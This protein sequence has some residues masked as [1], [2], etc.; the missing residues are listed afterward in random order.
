MKI[1]GFVIS[2][3]KKG[4]YFISQK[5]Y[6]EQIEEKLGFKPFP[7][8]LNIQIQEGNLEQIAK[9]PLEEI[10]TI[11]GK[12][13]FGDVKYIKASLNGEINGA[14]VFPVKTQHPQDI[15]EFIANVNLREHLT[16]EDGALVSLDIKVIQG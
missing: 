5:F 16:L 9:I 7:G 12:G 3:T 10:G 4:G 2:G 15:L 6:S 8:T 11:K 1:L 14:I 13:D